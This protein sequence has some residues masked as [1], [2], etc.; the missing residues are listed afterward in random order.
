MNR[1]LSVT[2]TVAAVLFAAVPALAQPNVLL[3][4]KSSGFEHDVVQGSPSVVDQ[5][6]GDA[7]AA[8]GGTLTATKDASTINASNLPNF[9]VVIF[10]TSGDLTTSG[11]DGNTPMGGTGV[12][13][14]NA[15]IQGGG[16]FIGF[17]S[18]TDTFHNDQ[19]Y[20]DMVGAEF[21]SHGSQFSTTLTV[22]APSHPVMARVPTNWTLTEEYYEFKN[23]AP[24]GRTP[25]IE[26]D[27][28]PNYALVWTNDYGTGRVL[29]SQLAHN[30]S[31]WDDSDFQNMLEDAISW[32]DTGT[33]STPTPDIQFNS[34]TVNVS[35]DDGIAVLTVNLSVAPGTGNSVTVDY[36]TENGTAIGGAD[37]TNTFGTLTISDTD[38][39]DSITVPIVNNTNLETDE[40]FSV[41]LT[42]PSGG[43]FAK[44]D[45]IATVVIADDEVDTDGDGFSD[46][47]ES[48][49]TFGYVTNANLAD[50]DGDGISDYMETF[51]G[52]DPTDAGSTPSLSTFPV[53]FV[54]DRH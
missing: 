28:S 27:G 2:A 35:E 17:H 9:D 30:E 5:K 49:G 3:L 16:G 51:L 50:T 18:A 52:T 42:N 22:V 34:S 25:L 53:P 24:T 40:S 13:E 19:D 11:S 15:W 54:K 44:A 33:S 43:V 46:Q 1:Y 41:R 14:L 26:I 31:T 20:I 38:T 8:L 29:Y 47:D 21:D 45:P 32:A 37:F 6:I 12:D 36:A 23:V 10:F 7:V 4:T 48:L 39:S